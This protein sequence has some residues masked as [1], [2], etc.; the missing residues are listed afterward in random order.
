[1]QDIVKDIPMAH[2][3]WLGKLLEPLSDEQIRDC[4]RAGGYLPEE[5]EG[6]AAAVKERIRA[7]NGL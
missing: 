3:K 2:V 4:F 1:M 6:Y 7:L 5:V